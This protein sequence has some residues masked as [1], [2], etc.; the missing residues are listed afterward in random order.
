MTAWTDQ[1][2]QAL[3]EYSRPIAKAALLDFRAAKAQ[4]L[5]HVKVERRTK[6]QALDT[7]RRKYERLRAEYLRI[8]GTT[9]A[10]WTAFGPADEWEECVAAAHDDAVW[11]RL[12]ER[13][14]VELAR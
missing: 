11:D 5:E 2:D 8:E 1:R 12:V 4:Q 6:R 10:A 7:L 13:G 9:Y 14:L 3:T